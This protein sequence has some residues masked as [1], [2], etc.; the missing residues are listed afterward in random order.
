MEYYKIMEELQNNKSGNNNQDIY[1]IA[2]VGDRGN[3][4]GRIKSVSLDVNDDIVIGVDIDRES[5]TG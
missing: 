2:S 5:V 1:V 4:L 3:H